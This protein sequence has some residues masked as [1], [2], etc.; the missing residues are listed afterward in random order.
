M[1]TTS[2]VK[3]TG[4]C[5]VRRQRH[6]VR[7]V[8][9][10][11]KMAEKLGVAVP[12]LEFVGRCRPDK[13]EFHSGD[14]AWSEMGL[15]QDFIVEGR[16]PVIE[17]DWQFVGVITYGHSEPRVWT[18]KPDDTDEVRRLDI[19]SPRC[20][21][22]ETLRKRDRIMV[23]RNGSTGELHMLG[24]NCV[25]DFL[26]GAARDL[27]LL[28]DR[29]SRLEIWIKEV[30]EEELVDGER[31][32]ESTA[33]PLVTLLAVTAFIVK[34]T[35][36]YVSRTESMN[37]GTTSTPVDAWLFIS[38]G[39][40]EDSEARAQFT[41]E[42]GRWFDQA[43][44]AI[45]WA[46]SIKPSNE[47]E[48]SIRTIARD[49]WFSVR[50]RRS[51]TAL[52]A[53]IW[54]AFMRAQ[55]VDVR[56]TNDNL[57]EWHGIV[58]EREELVLTVIRKLAHE[59]QFGTS[60]RVEMRDAEGRLFVWWCSRPAAVEEVGVGSTVRLLAS[61]KEH[62]DWNGVRQTVLTRCKVEEVGQPA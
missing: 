62:K 10:L 59:T 8:G 33:F 52:A 53:S 39:R 24:S 9:E 26:G 42:Q 41:L 44:A 60:M 11:A 6:L 25:Q 46:A 4:T 2:R 7:K 45:A 28:V 12:T 50:G 49:G 19:S 58:G 5:P 43:K 23:V 29:F 38:A 54:S 16:T 3:L 48:R 15:V 35:G 13:I 30:G 18:I 14:G 47:Y 27:A 61:I 57:N 37:R 56:R 34:R 55:A 31:D 36:R 20:V 1:T 21:H 51:E 40:T 17:G 32:P 22:C